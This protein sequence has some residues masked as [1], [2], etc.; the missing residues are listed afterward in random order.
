MKKLNYTKSGHAVDQ[1]ILTIPQTPL[2]T[3]KEEIELAKAMERGRRASN[4]LQ[5]H[6]LSAAEHTRLA[7]IIRQ[8]K[9]AR[10]KLVEANIRL[11]VSIANKYRDWGVPF[12]DLI[13]E[14]TLGLIHAADKFDYKRGFRFSTYATWWIRQSITRAI[15]DQS[16]TIRTP[17]HAWEKINQVRHTSAKLT[18]K[19]GR[20]PTRED[21]AKELGMTEKKVDRL[22]R[23]SEQPLSLEQLV[24]AEGGANL[25]DF[26]SDDITPEPVETATRH[27]L[28][29]E[30]KGVLTSLSPR[31]EQ[32]LE[33]RFGLNDGQ[34]HTLEEIGD[35]LGYT[36]E[37]IRQIE[38]EALRKLRHHTQNPKLRSYLN[39]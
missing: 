37:R 4:R 20:K 8:G 6:R 3:A 21:I 7:K 5:R 34:G 17:V 29:D 23:S 13:Q 14:G 1:H 31:E 19:L 9:Q 24:G 26:I 25:G 18:Q 27:L 16:H 22:M 2:L 38:R 33:L 11:V 32:V 10:E 36:R 12:W 30:L 28:R 15:A 39:N 35:E